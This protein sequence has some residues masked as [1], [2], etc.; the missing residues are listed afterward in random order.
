MRPRKRILIAGADVDRVSWLRFLLR[1]YLY[2]VG[3]CA[4]SAEAEARLGEAQWDLLLCDM[5]LDRVEWLLRRADKIDPRTSTLVMVHDAT[6]A[7]VYT[8]DKT[9]C[10]VAIDAAELLQWVKILSARKRGPQPM[11]KP[12]GSVGAPLPTAKSLNLG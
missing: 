11:K 9:L 6:P 5:P 12:V 8:A 7:L 1:T 2:G 4:S 10:G 3:A